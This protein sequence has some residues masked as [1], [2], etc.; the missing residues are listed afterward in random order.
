MTRSSAGTR[1]DVAAIEVAPGIHRITLPTPFIVGPVNVYLLEGDPPT[2][3][4]SGPG[5]A[6]NMLALEQALA[7]LGCE[8]PDIGLFVIT[9]Q[10]PDHLGLTRPLAQRSGGEV[11]ALN[12][13]AAVIGDYHRRLG[14]D[15]DY[16]AGLM[17]RHGFDTDLVHTLRTLARISGSY[18]TSA[19]VTK[20]LRDSQ[21]IVLGGRRFTVLH[22]PGHSP[23]D[24]LLHNEDSGLLLSGDHL[25][26]AISSNALLALPLDDPR[27]PRRRPRPLLEYRR[28]LEQT[29]ALDVEVVLPGHGRPFAEHRDLIDRRL[30][31]QDGRADALLGLLKAGPRTAQ[32]LAHE[33]W[34]P[35]ALDQAPLTLSE[36]LGHLDLLIEAGLV[37]EHESAD[38][39]FFEAT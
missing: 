19:Q 36:V 28:S 11:A 9:H 29:R 16:V 39:V 7:S 26:P 6:T 8:L 10:H 15:D 21:Q 22:R 1:D 33:V 34:G 12:R 23:S 35:A 13:A 18:G 20:P 27:P 25:L 37:S 30:A 38:P 4:D 32:E 3:V 14:A 5:L 24:I 31:E 17:R 2:L